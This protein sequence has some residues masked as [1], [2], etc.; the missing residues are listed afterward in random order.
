MI[1]RH[2][3]PVTLVFVSDAAATHLV[4]DSG[5]TISDVL[6]EAIQHARVRFREYEAGKVQRVRVV[7]RHG[8]E[9][10]MDVELGLLRY[11]PGKVL[12]VECSR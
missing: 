8:V 6:G 9:Q 4:A 3:F 11:P 7:D 2:K 1:H 5:S 10:P 12:Y